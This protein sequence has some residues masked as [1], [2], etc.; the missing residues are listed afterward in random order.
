M[1]THEHVPGSVVV[2]GERVEVEGYG[3][4]GAV[5]TVA[6]DPVSVRAALRDLPAGTALVILTRAAAAAVDL[7]TPHTPGPQ[8][9]VLP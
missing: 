1:N 7:P 9:V 6:E 2:I 8:V 3:P 4:A 5:V